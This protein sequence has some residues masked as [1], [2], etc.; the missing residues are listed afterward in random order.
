MALASNMKSTFASKLDAYVWAHG[1][2]VA[3][4]GRGVALAG[5]LADAKGVEVD[6]GHKGHNKLKAPATATCQKDRKEKSVV[7]GRHENIRLK[8]H[9]MF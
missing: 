9:S 1:P 8:T 7:N 6:K 4:S 5:V 3:S 2:F